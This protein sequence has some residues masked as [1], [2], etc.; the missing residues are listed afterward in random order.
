MQRATATP[1]PVG[2]S[3]REARGFYFRDNGFSEAMYAAPSIPIPIGR[4]T[5]NSPNPP[6]RG[7]SI[8]IHD[9]HHVLT[10]FGTDNVGEVEIS[11]WEV[12]AGLG[13]RLVPWLI[14]A[15]A[16]ALG[17]LRWPC[18]AWRAF[19]LGRMSRS[20]FGNEDEIPELLCLT[21]AEARAH[22]QI[23]AQGVAAQAGGLHPMAPAKQTEN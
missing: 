8:A 16:F 11:A 22:M 12:G 18:R 13:G 3:L 15:P 1:I 17:M 19:R 9:I 6:A 10:G 7:R 23:P 20:L 5:W 14:S 4:Y 2:V 21:V